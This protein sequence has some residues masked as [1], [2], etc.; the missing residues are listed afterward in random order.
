MAVMRTEDWK[1]YLSDKA[2]SMLEDG[3]KTLLERKVQ[4]P[5]RA[6]K[7][8]FVLTA[9]I[10]N[11]QLLK[12]QQNRTVES[13][14]DADWSTFKQEVFVG[15]RQAKETYGMLD[16]VLNTCYRRGVLMEKEVSAE[17]YVSWALDH[18]RWR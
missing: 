12:G 14:M 17:G 16:N 15:V 2:L 3:F 7:A 1:A 4:D 6:A 18:A 5:N 13:K 9:V 8:M 11:V 10:D